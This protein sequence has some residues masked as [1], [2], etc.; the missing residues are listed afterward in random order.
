MAQMCAVESMLKE[1]SAFISSEKFIEKIQ[2]YI[3]KNLRYAKI[4]M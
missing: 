1:M 3:E 2:R 4:R